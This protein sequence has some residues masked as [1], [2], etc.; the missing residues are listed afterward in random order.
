[1]L[2]TQK[3]KHHENISYD[4]ELSLARVMFKVAG[5]EETKNPTLLE[6]REQHKE[7]NKIMNIAVADRSQDD[8]KL[9][10]KTITQVSK[11]IMLK[12]N[13]VETTSTLTG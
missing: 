1:M 10:N 7:F 11:A 3:R 8:R 12:A 5:F 2:K 6:L 4:Y 13:F 9:L